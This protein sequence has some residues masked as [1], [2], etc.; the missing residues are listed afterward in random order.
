MPESIMNMKSRNQYLFALISKSGG[1]HLKGRKEKKKILDQYCRVTGQHRKWVI[2]KIRSGGYVKSMRIEEDQKA[3]IKRRRKCTYNN[4]VAAYLIKLWNI[5]DHPCGQRLVTSIQDEL[6]RLRRFG[7][8]TMSD[9]MAVKLTKA[10]ARTIDEKLKIHKQKEFLKRKYRHKLHPLLYQKIPVKIRS[11]QQGKEG[12]H[13]QIDLVEHC[14][15][16][17]E[18]IFLFSLSTTDISTGWWEGEVIWGKDAPKVVQA[19]KATRSRYPFPWN[20]I[21]SD[22]GSEFINVKMYSYTEKEGLN[23]SRSRPYKKNDNCFV[24]QKNGT[25]IRK[26]VGYVRYDTPTE[27]QIITQLYSTTL[28]LYKNFFQPVMMLKE[29]ERRGSHVTRRYDIPKTPYQ[30]VLASPRVGKEKKNELKA[31][32]ATLNPAELKRRIERLQDELYRAYRAKQKHGITE[33]QKIEEKIPFTTK[34][35]TPHWVSNYIAEREV[36]S[37]H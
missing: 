30:R 15:Q 28:N 29:K 8:L 16:K 19:L 3:G 27:Q 14:G 6:P 33:K 23:F 13:I 34:K 10:S 31:L 18:G 25:H 35:H 9:E 22:N 21:H 7:E 24:E 37:V 20:G 26:I 5:F 36:I 1:Y 11:D 32:Y 17:G 12:A 2:E 4:E